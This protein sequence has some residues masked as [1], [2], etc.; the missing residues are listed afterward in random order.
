M[1]PLLR[2]LKMRLAAIEAARSH[3]SVFFLFV[4]L[5]V[6]LTE[7]LDPSCSIHQLLFSSEKRMAG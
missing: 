5:C 3:F 6:T 1:K 7:F 4:V 2:T